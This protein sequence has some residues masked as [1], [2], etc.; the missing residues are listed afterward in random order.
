[1]SK[2]VRGV[3]AAVSTPRNLDG[4][5]DE[6]SLQKSL[7]FLLE[8]DIRGFA[9]NGATGEY[10]VT[11]TDELK[12]ILTIAN[13]V[14][15]GSAD[16]VVGVGSAGIQGCLANGKLVIDSG[17]AGVL[18][19]MPHFF[20]YAQDDLAAFCTEVAEALPIPILLYNLPQFTSGL[21]SATVQALITNCPNIVGIKDSSG[22]LETLRDLTTHAIDSCRIVG[23]D[24]AFADSLRHQVSDGVI[25]GVAGVLP[26]LIL[27]LYALKSETDSTEFSKKDALLTEFIRQI[28][29][30]P[31]PWGLKIIGEILGIA[32]ASFS[33]PLSARR[34]E[35]KHALQKWFREWSD[36]GQPNVAA[37]LF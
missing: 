2:V 29:A 13:Q 30:V 17:A 15:N 1:M 25:S 11:T 24:S 10:C 20:P 21:D 3:F 18:L 27:S 19:P 33:Q 22:S 23:N 9:I 8:H 7:S 34:M 14:I 4:S 37:H 16:F 26:K 6:K 12:K 28:N 31:T 36:F 5:I 32:P 35:Q